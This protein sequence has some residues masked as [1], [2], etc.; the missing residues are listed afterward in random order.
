MAI[1]IVGNNSNKIDAAETNIIQRI[2][3]AHAE[4][5]TP[6]ERIANQMTGLKLRME[7]YLND[8]SSVEIIPAGVFLAEILAT[9]R[10]QKNKFAKHIDLEVPNLHAILKGRR[11]INNLI[12]KKIELTFEIDEEIWLY[13]ETKNA[14]KSFN[15]NN[16][17]AKNKYKID[18]LIA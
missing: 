15:Q 10:I 6:A 13:I 9:Y 4:E 18:R 7:R 17:L 5:Q 8:D 11:K 14:I 12:A 1:E 2:I 16:S 3:S